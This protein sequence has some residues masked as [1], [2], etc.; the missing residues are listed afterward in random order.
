[1]RNQSVFYWHSSRLT[2]PAWCVDSSTRFLWTGE[3]MTSLC[4]STW[5]LRCISELFCLPCLVD[6]CSFKSTSLHCWHDLISFLNC[7]M[8]RT[9]LDWRSATLRAAVVTIKLCLLS[10][11]ASL[12]LLSRC[13]F[14]HGSSWENDVYVLPLPTFYFWSHM[15]GK[16][17]W[18]RSLMSSV[19]KMSSGHKNNQKKKSQH[20]ITSCLWHVKHLRLELFFSGLKNIFHRLFY[21]HH[22]SH[23]SPVLSNCFSPFDLSVKKILSQF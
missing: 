2:L 19:E 18:I 16:G 10:F 22:I 4:L 1:M 5:S 23:S 17:R 20:Q 12:D 9:F 6:L 11:D 7:L 8:H 13:A 14:R 15:V 3:Y 21:K